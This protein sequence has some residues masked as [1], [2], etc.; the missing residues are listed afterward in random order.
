[1]P[2]SLT[3][4]GVQFPDNSTQ[5]TALPAPGTYGNVLTS[6]GTNWTSAAAPASAGAFT[7]TASGSISAGA[8]VLINSTGQAYVQTNT[9]KTGFFGSLNFAGS[10]TGYSYSVNASTTT[11]IKYSFN[12]VS[13]THRIFWK[14]SG[15]SYV[16]TSYGSTNLAGTSYS[17]V[18]GQNAAAPGTNDTQYGNEYGISQVVFAP[19]TSSHYYLTV[20]GGGNQQLKINFVEDDSAG[21]SLSSNSADVGGGS[22][23]GSPG[24]NNAKNYEIAISSSDKLA[25]VWSDTSNRLFC[26]VATVSTSSPYWTWG[27]MLTINSG[28]T[29]HSS[30]WHVGVAWGANNNEFVVTY[31]DSSSIVKATLISV[32]GTTCTLQSTAN[33]ASSTYPSSDSRHSVCFVSPAN[34]Y[35]FAFYTDSTA[36]SPATANSVYLVAAT[37]S[38]TALTFGSMVDVYPY[39][40]PNTSRRNV[41]YLYPSPVVTNSFFL[42]S[43]TDG[44]SGSYDLITACSVSGTAI[45]VIDG[46]LDYVVYNGGSYGTVGYVSSLGAQTNFYSAGGTSSSANFTYRYTSNQSNN[47][48]GFSSLSYTNGQAAAV[49][50][51]GGINT[52]QSGLIAGKRYWF[53]LSGF[54]GLSAS[55]SYAGQAL[56][57]TS[58][59]VK[60]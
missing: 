46:P 28:G 13:G 22:Y 53:Q 52:N 56:S 39:G 40:T 9:Y 10:N 31:A 17:G 42:H 34:S 49:N 59:L 29:L 27:S 35:I 11:A 38:G 54:L 50:S 2:T 26:A 51:V 3:A 12:S 15:V 58:I 57:A 44:S 19:T 41:C 47:F 55:N 43:S 45:T 20:P 23:A 18:T 33:V 7:A 48:A 36:T 4:T 37:S 32:S 25:V 16:F 6:I 5:T 1:M 30:Q 8:P 60:G 14:G 21:A 24:I